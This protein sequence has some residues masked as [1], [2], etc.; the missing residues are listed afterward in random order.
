MNVLL[1][2]N[3]LGWLL[4]GLSA[5]ELIPVGAALILGEPALPPTLPTPHFGEQRLPSR[6]K[7]RS[8]LQESP[9]MV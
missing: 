8:H 7:P 6:L 5:I 2:A 1:I 4:L 9:K 3:F